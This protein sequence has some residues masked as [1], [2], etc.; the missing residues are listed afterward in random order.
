MDVGK[1]DAVAALAA[2]RGP[3]AWGVAWRDGAASGRHVVVG[4]YNRTISAAGTSG[5]VIGQCRLSTSGTPRDTRNNQPLVVGTVAIAHNG[6]VRDHERRARELG[7][8]LST[9]CDSELLAHIIARDGLERALS[10][11]DGA[12]YALLVLSPAGVAA[13]RRGHPLYV[14]ATAYGTYVCSVPFEGAIMIDEGTTMLKAAKVVHRVHPI[15]DVCWVEPATLHANSYNPNKVFTPEMQLL[16]L[17]ILEDG[18]TQPIVA[19]TG[20]E[21]VDG[22][23]R[24][25]LAS[26]DA[27][28]RAASGDRCPVV[29]LDGGKSV[30]DQMIATVRHNRARGQ[31]GVL[32]MGAIVRALLEQGLTP[33]Q[34]EQRLGM[35]DEEIERLSDVRSSLEHAGKDSFGKGWVPAGR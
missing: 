26:T 15:S 22:F 10:L 13:A 6:N 31:H 23:H 20:G 19:R 4:A 3:H 21:I 1:L 14:H 7:V 35:E 11:L 29:Y 30:A 8:T 34:I 33:E 28:V 18:W 9:S 2:R 16:K 5:S 24:W 12:P 17:S 32:K 25:T 27:E